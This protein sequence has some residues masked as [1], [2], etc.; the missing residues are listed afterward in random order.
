MDGPKRLA[1]VFVELADTLVAEFDMVD[2]L[3]TLTER[4]VELLHADAAGLML[5]DERGELRL[6]AATTERMRVVE[7]L[8]LQVNEGPCRDCFVTGKAVTNVDLAAAR[9]RWPQFTAAA[10]AAGFGGTHALPMRLRGRV[11][12]A[13]NLFTDEHVGLSDEDVAV[14]QAMADIATIGLIHERTL[15]EQTVVSEQLQSALHSRVLVEQAKGVLAA[16]AG[17]RVDDAFQRMRDHARHNGLT[18]TAVAT[19]I[20][21]GTLDTRILTRL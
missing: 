8:E 18:L 17:I 9:E 5:A 2:L 13:L 19:G 1:E 15:R 14:G 16:Q 7:L 12:G 6:M 3:Q 4:C 20:V 21:E 10:V 11:I